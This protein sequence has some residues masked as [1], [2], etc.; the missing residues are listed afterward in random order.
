MVALLLDEGHE[1]L[2]ISRS[3]EVEF[4]FRPYSWRSHRGTFLF[5]RIDLNNSAALEAALVEFSPDYVINFAA[6]SMVA[7]SWITPEDWYST[8]LIGMLGLLRALERLPALRKFVQVTTPEVYGSTNGWVQE[9]QA[10]NPSTPYAV[11]RAAADM[12]LMAFQSISNL[13]ICLTRAA[14]VFGPGQQLY[15]IIPRALLYARTGRILRLD[16]GGISTRS[17]I[18]IGDVVRATYSVATEG[19]PGSVFH[20]STD[21]VCTVRELVE[22]ICDL[23]G[24]AISDLVSD[25]P[26]RPGKDAAYL[27]DSSKIRQELGWSPEISLAQGLAETLVWIDTNLDELRNSPDRYIHK[28]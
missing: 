25:G 12:H 28:R 4:P 17:F 18:H 6:Q 3:N 26:E 15:R 5:Q 2:G 8:N 20:I 13:P 22:A 7:E 11:S 23:T 10:F 19:M 9:D 14:N 21:S 1:V 24:V 27:L 16:G